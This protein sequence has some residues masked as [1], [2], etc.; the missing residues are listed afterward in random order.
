MQGRINH[1]KRKPLLA[2]SPK[3]WRT[4]SPAHARWHQIEIRKYEG[5]KNIPHIFDVTLREGEKEREKKRKEK[6]ITK[7]NRL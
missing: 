3:L 4:T 6:K 7:E 5:E 2:A 1:P